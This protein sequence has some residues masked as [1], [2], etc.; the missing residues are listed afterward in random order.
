MKPACSA[1]LLGLLLPLSAPLPACMD[2]PTWKNVSAPMS[3]IVREPGI[4]TSIQP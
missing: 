3:A 2:I 4:F 1:L